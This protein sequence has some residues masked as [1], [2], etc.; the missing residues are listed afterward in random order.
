MNINKERLESCT[1]I[2]TIWDEVFGAVG[3]PD[4]DKAEAEAEMF[5][6]AERLKEERIHAGLT[7]QQLADKIGK[8]KDY[9]SQIENC[10]RDIHITTLFK[11]FS[12]L[13][14]RVCVSIL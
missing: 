12:G 6:L 13:G 3:T 14:K 7:Q 5:C 10:K 11:L 1:P 8:N 9:I 4:R 2:N